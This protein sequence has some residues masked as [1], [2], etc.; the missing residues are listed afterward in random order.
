MWQ[1]VRAELEKWDRTASEFHEYDKER[2][3]LLER[4]AVE[5]TRLEHEHDGL[6]EQGK[7]IDEQAPVIGGLEAEARKNTRAADGGRRKS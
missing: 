6:V 3:P 7:V 2:V 1:Q 4:I 5:R